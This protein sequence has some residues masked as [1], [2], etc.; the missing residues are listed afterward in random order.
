MKGMATLSYI[1]WATRAVIA[2]W[3]LQAALKVWP[4]G[5]IKPQLQAAVDEV[6]A[7]AKR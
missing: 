3:L 5:K 4:D 7:N 6:F 1:G 2:S